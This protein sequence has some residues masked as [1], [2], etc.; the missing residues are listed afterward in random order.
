MIPKLLAAG[1]PT[2]LT[3]PASKGFKYIEVTGQAHITSSTADTQSSVSIIQRDSGDAIKREFGIR[4]AENGATG[5]L[6]CI[7]TGPVA[8]ADGDYFTLEVREETD[9]SVTIE[10]DATAE[11]FLSLHVIGMEPV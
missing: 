6:R 3:I 8:V 10:G 2:R 5:W 1:V 9:N 7:G 4:F 11:T